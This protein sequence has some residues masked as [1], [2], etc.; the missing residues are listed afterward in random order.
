MGAVYRGIRADDQFQQTVAI[1]M[2][3][4]ATVTG[5]CSSA[6]VA[7]GKILA[8]LEHPYIARLLDGGEWIPPG[9]LEGQPYIV[10]E[11]VEG[12]TLTTY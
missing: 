3:R 5:W 12:L 1:K 10:M 11:F 9:S 2:L 4:F 8:G 7:S 6:F